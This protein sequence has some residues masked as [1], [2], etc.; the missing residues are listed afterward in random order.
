MRSFIDQGEP[1]H[2]LL[3]EVLYN[4]MEI[5][6]TTKL[7][8]GIEIESGKYKHGILTPEKGL[9]D[10]LSKREIEVLRLLYTDL[11]VP[12]ISSHLHISVSTLRTHIRNIYEKL[13]VHSR[14]EATTK[15]KDLGLT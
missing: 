5:D 15:G 1:M 7:I 11:S 3:Q 6:Y 2:E 14:F 12:E 10:P 8:H 9:I 13:G 4:G